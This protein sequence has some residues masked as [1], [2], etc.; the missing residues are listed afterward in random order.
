MSYIVGK[1]NL[2]FTNIPEKERHK[3]ERFGKVYSESVLNLRFSRCCLLDS[4]AEQELA[5]K[6]KEKF[7]YF[8]FGGILGDNPP[9]GRTKVLHKL[10]C[11]MRNLGKEQMSTDTA[12]L[13][14]NMILNG[15]KLNEITFKDTIELETNEGESVILPYRY[16]VENGKPVLPKGLFEMLKNQEGL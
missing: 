16:V 6:D 7:E 14:T 10:N 11:D 1:E 12:V 13:V 9:R 8:I 4:V 15:K 3:L 2:I 5:T